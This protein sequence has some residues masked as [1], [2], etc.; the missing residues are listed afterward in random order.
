M[1][2]ITNDPFFQFLMENKPM[3]GSYAYA[4]ALIERL[5]LDKNGTSIETDDYTYFSETIEYCIRLF[6]TTAN[7]LQEAKQAKEA[8][9]TV[10]GFADTLYAL[11]IETGFLE[12][13]GWLHNL[14]GRDD[15]NPLLDYDHP[16][17]GVAA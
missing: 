5:L 10:L 1:S 14:M 2:S 12:Q 4:N 7:E 11:A 6:E 13:D 16:S 15:Y 3:V 17:Q 9:I 8:V